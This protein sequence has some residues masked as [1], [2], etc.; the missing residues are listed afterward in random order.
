MSNVD[1][2]E[3]GHDNNK[4]EIL[5]RKWSEFHANAPKTMLIPSADGKAIVLHKLSESPLVYG[6]PA[7]YSFRHG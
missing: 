2:T 6:A 7:D 3:P 5:R 4:D 1:Q